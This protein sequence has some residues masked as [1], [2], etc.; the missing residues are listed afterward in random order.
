MTHLL[1]C[2]EAWGKDEEAL[3]HP[4][5]GAS[6]SFL[7]ESLARVGLIDLSPSDKANLREYY[8]SGKNPYFNLLV[9]E[10]H[11]EIKLTN[12]LNLRPKPSNDIKN[13]C[14]PKAQGVPEM[15]SIAQGKYLRAEYQPELDRLYKEVTAHKPNLILAVGGTAAWAF[16]KTS[17]ISKIRGSTAESPF[18]KVLPTY[19]PAA[20]L[21]DYSNRPIFLADLNKAKRESLFPEVRR[22]RRE[23]WI[24]P[25]IEDIWKFH[26]QFVGHV[27]A[28]D[29]E[30]VGDMITCVGLSPDPQH[31]L[32]IPF[33]DPTKPG[34]NYW[35]KPEDELLAW[36]YIVQLCREVNTVFQNGMYDV[37]FLWRAMGIPVLRAIED[38]MLLHHALQ[39]ELSKG[40]GFLGSVY[41]DEASWKI[42][43]KS[44]TAKR[45]E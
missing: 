32:V 34:K 24:E 27:V 31:S 37:H 20:I 29:I 16:L 45:E 30:T 36:A 44:A 7:L 11:R 23:V 3:E 40:L 10:A 33:F 41:T 26:N 25:T 5:V 43:R 15:P 4:F 39:P 1:I 35:A 22:P 18:G 17:G 19:H 38:T 14:G 2:G 12:V 21:R 9:W 13:C 42:M 28:L 6:G 8:R